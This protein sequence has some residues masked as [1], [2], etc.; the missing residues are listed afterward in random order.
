MSSDEFGKINLADALRRLPGPQKQNSVSLF[1]H[2]SMVVKLYAP[3]GSDAQTP[4]SRDEIYVI[5]RG[6]GEFVCGETRQPFAV[7]DVLFVASGLQHRFENFT[8][9]FATWVL[10][11]GP[12]GGEIDLS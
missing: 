5:A 9:D 4:H 3:V 12:E 10:F 6:A 7:N 2:G 8:D 1:E 11:Y